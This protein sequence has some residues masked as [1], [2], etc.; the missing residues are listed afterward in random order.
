MKLTV[1][2]KLCLQILSNYSKIQS[3]MYNVKINGDI[4]SPNIEDRFEKTLLIY[5]SQITNMSIRASEEWEKR[6]LR[7]IKDFLSRLQRQR[8]TRHDAK[9]RQDR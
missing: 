3:L 2:L 6:Y 4:L 7:D 9:P 5:S 8:K 1:A